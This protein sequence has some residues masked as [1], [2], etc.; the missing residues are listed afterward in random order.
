[1]STTTTKAPERFTVTK[2]NTTLT[3]YPYT[4]K[5]R[6]NWRFAWK[7]T[8][9]GGKWKY[10]TRHTKEEAKAAAQEKLE[11]IAWGGLAWSALPSARQTF[12]S[13]VHG[14]THPDDEGRVLEFAYSLRRERE[15]RARIAAAALGNPS[16]IG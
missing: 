7:D 6:P 14:D 16:K 8:R 4:V 15:E 10:V 3:V 9:D 12:L 1:M 2:H 11:E 5:G 13:T